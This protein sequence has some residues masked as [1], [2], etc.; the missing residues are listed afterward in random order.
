M[1]A[2][3][4]E[5]MITSLAAAL[6]FVAK[7]GCSA[8]ET[9]I[10][11]VTGVCEEIGYLTTIQKHLHGRITAAEGSVKTH[12]QDCKMFNVSMLQS[13]RS[14]SNAVY[15]TL[16]AEKTMRLRKAETLL[17]DTATELQHPLATLAAR[18]RQI[19]AA[20]FTNSA[21]AY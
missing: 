18:I 6:L 3:I 1:A 2:T 9:S 20:K 17:R 7:H 14:E 11:A 15:L 21:A 5:K 12:N 8:T 10:N 19:K 16:A 13:S 4:T